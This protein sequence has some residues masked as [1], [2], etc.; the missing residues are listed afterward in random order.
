MLF[1]YVRFE[2]LMAVTMKNAVFWDVVPCRCVNRRYEG[3][4]RPHLQGKK[5]M[6]EELA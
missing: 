6:S 4:Y 3:T 1:T 5:S 2:V